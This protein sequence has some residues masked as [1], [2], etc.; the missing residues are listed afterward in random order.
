[1]SGAM[2]GDDNAYARMV[3]FRVRFKGHENHHDLPPSPQPA[4][5]GSQGPRD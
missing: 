3:E 5:Q 4:R 1:M 2:D